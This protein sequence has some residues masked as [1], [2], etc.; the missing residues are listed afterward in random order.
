MRIAIDIDGTVATQGSPENN[1]RDSVV[2]PEMVK[3]VNNLYEQEIEVIFYTARHNKHHVYTE[4]FL[5]DAGFKFHFLYCSKISY[6]LLLDDKAF[7]WDNE[8]Q[9]IM[10]DAET[11]IKE[12][13]MKNG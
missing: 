4:Q 13:E 8:I 9:N 12:L 7:R 2:K 5:R 11:L 10:M 6:D 1:Y 3:F